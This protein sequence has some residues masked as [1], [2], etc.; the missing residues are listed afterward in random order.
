MFDNRAGAS[1]LWHLAN[2]KYCDLSVRHSLVVACDGAV[3]YQCSDSR[4]LHSS[5]GAFLLLLVCLQTH[6]HD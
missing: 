1:S 6:V 3:G 5:R 4:L 2:L